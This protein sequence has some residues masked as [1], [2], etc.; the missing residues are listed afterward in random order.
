M[1]F[2]SDLD[3]SDMEHNVVPHQKGHFLFAESGD[4]ER[5]E[6]RVFRRRACR[7]ERR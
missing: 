1:W 5:E 2:G 6:Q 4:Q 7:E 3:R